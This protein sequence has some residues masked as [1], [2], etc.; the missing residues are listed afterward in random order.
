MKHF[1]NGGHSLFDRQTDRQTDRQLLHMS[2]SHVYSDDSLNYVVSGKLEMFHMLYVLVIVC[3]DAVVQPNTMVIKVVNAFLTHAA[4]F[5]VVFDM[6][7]TAVA[8]QMI[9]DI[10]R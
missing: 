4:M 10:H 9:G 1:Q 8:E 6:S 3:A 2:E 5:A 7:I